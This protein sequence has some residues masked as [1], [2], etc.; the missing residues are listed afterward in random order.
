LII[1]IIGLGLG[2]WMVGLISDLLQASQGQESLRYAMLIL[3][4]AVMAWSAVH[5]YLAS[6]HLKSDL[7]IVPD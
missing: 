4:P 2:P 7:E 6:R 3:L 1:N 5:F